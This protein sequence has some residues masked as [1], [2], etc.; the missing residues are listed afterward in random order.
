M[1]PKEY[2]IVAKDHRREYQRQ[3]RES[4]S[5]YGKKWREAHPGYHQQK[6][7][8][9]QP[10]AQANQ[11]KA[12]NASKIIA[13]TH[14]GNGKC[15]CVHCGFKDLRALTLDHINGGGS[16]ERAEQKRNHKRVLVGRTLC[17]W[18]HL[19]GFPVGFQTLCMNCQFIKRYTH[20]EHK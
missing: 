10:I 15:A 19:R 11:R 16:K 12:E 2:N 5:D 9:Y 1:I 3:W 4:H 20:K 7:R 13:L 14:Y 8:E 18:L 17:R 6:S